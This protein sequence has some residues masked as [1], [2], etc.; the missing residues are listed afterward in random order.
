MDSDGMR[1]AFNRALAT[2]KPDHYLYPIK[3]VQS[4]YGGVYEGG[5]WVSFPNCDHEPPEAAFGDDDECA[6]YWASRRSRFVGRGSTPDE[7]YGDMLRRLEQE[8]YD[9]A[10]NAR[11]LY[12]RLGWALHCENDS[13]MKQLITDL[14]TYF[15]ERVI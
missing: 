8:D 4:R 15:A 2:S 1:Q 14:R 5:A 12:A 3:V 9:S 6:D 7:A 10:G 13:T 11:Q